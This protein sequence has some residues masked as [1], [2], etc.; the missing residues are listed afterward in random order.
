MNLDFIENKLKDTDIEN[1]IICFS[2]DPDGEYLHIGH[3]LTLFVLNEIK[4]K[5]NCKFILRFD[6]ITPNNKTEF[7][8]NFIIEQIKWLGIEFDEITYAS[9]HLEQ[10]Y[11]SALKLIENGD[12]YV[13]NMSSQE[14]HKYRGNF[15]SEGTACEGRNN[16]IDENKEEFFK[17]VS[18]FYDENQ[19]VLRAK[20]D[21]N[22]NNILYRDPILYRVINKRHYRYGSKWNVYPLYLFAEP[23]EDYYDNISHLI[24]TQNYRD[25]KPVYDWVLK[26]TDTHYNP[27]RVEYGRIQITKNV[28][29]KNILANLVKEK[30]VEGWDDQRLYTILSMRKRGFDPLILKDYLLNCAVAKNDVKIPGEKIEYYMK[31][32]FAKKIEKSVCIEKAAI[33]VCEGEEF[34]IEQEDACRIIDNYAKGERIIRLFDYDYVEVICVDS[35]NLKI[36]ARNFI[37]ENI[38]IPVIPCINKKCSKDAFLVK[39]YSLLTENCKSHADIKKILNKKSKEIIPIKVPQRNYVENQQIRFLRIGY[40]HVIITERSEYLFVLDVN[41]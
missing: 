35:N 22:S 21:L 34:F 40:T 24:L 39:Y 25:V 2:A 31:K 28:L 33:I 10:M 13:C 7:Y 32:S 41:E 15:S 37:G 4:K 27:F 11:F 30:I 20:T 5:Y 9:E 17:M 19:V 23:F 29:N 26:K 16:S 3:A 18:G 14:I 1:G 8:Q 12:A 6:D 36:Y 38:R